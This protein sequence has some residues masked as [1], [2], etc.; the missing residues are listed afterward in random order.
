MRIDDLMSESGVAFG[1][2]GARGP[3]AAMTDRVCWTYTLGFLQYLRAC[4]RIGAAGEVGLAGD[5]RPSSGRILAACTAAVTAMGLRPRYFGRIPS[6]ALAAFGIAAG[7]P[8][9]MVTGSHIP[10]DRNGIKFNRPDGEILKDDEAGIRAQRV[11][12]PPGMFTPAGAFVPGRGS[13]LPPHDGAALD[14]YVA[15]YLGFFPRD[16][17]AGV[18][19]GLYEHSTVAREPLLAILTGLG[20]EVARLGRSEAFIPV[21]TEAVRPEDVAL[22]REW[23][24]DGRFDALVSADGDGDRPLVADAQGHWL[25]G[26]VAGILCARAL[27]AVGVVTPVSSNTALE[28]CGWFAR[29][30]RTRIGSPYVIAGMAELGA[31]GLAPIV[32]YEANGGFLTATDIVA[33]DRRLPALPTRDA[34]IVAVTLLAA[35]PGRGRPLS[36]LVGNLPARFT[37]SDRLK[38]FPTEISRA[39]LAALMTGDGERDRQAVAGLFAGDFGPVAALDSTDGLRITFASGAI[40]HLRPSGNAPELRAYTEADSPQAAQAM[41]RRCLEILAGWRR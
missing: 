24:A 21:D 28:R 6:P 22:A 34:A 19:V 8:T 31:E 25:R 36:A 2:S 17:L 12:V 10:D 11:E 5:L 33:D 16:C 14:A 23:A 13:D 29:V 37:D 26:D 41:T 38:D 32:G 1:T 35:G 15:R 40:A 3:A 7:I 27:G 39:R 9:M 30:V 4:G 18:R 20:A